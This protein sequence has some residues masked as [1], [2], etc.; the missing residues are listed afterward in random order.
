MLRIG[1]LMPRSTLYPALGLDVLNGFKLCLKQVAIFDDLKLLMDNIGFGTD[2]QEIYTKAEKMLL[3]EDADI[4][5]VCADARIADMLQPLFTASNKLLLVV[6]FGANLPE[7][8]QLSAT[9]IV[10]SINFAWQTALTGTLAAAENNVQAAN[11]ISYYDGGYGQCFTMLNN[12]QQ[13]GG[14]P[15]F[16]HITHL[17][18]SEFTLEPLAQF[19]DEYSDVQ[20]LLCLFSGDQAIR[21]YEDIMPL[22]AKY[23]LSLYVSPMLLEEGIQP[24]LKKDFTIEKVKGHVPWHSTLQNDHNKL[25]KEYS[26]AANQVVNY[27]SLLGWDTGLIVQA[28]YQ[29]YQTGIT[30]A[31]QI[32]KVITGKQLPSPRGWLTIDATTQHSYGPSYLATVAGNF[33]I[34]IQQQPIPDVETQWRL[35]TQTTMPK[36]ESSS[37]RNTYLCI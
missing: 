2:E 9:T 25:F 16:N 32:V 14:T 28:V 23:N 18:T 13:L 17:K 36:G 34:T 8:W 22:Q 29:Q 19:L 5:I 35:F 20:T 12:H 7:T 6:N 4:V 37:W 10:H 21:F 1:I 3:Q 30:N 26:A 15:R 27:F 33:E 24:L 11:V 31:T